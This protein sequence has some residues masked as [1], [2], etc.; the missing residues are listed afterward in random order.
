MNVD[1]D[2][3]HFQCLK[4]IHTVNEGSHEYIW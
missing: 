3:A 1:I 2:E 4:V